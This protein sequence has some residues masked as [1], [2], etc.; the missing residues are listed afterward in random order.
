MKLFFHVLDN[1][2][3]FRTIKLLCEVLFP[4]PL[5]GNLRSWFTW[6]GLAWFAE[7]TFISILHKAR[8]NGG[9]YSEQYVTYVRV[10][11]NLLSC[12]QLGSPG[13]PGESNYIEKIQ[14][15]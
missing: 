7:V 4:F 9:V 14:R 11:C 1:N 6:A 5:Y 12:R 10:I 2:N 3:N 13:W 8:R 15:G